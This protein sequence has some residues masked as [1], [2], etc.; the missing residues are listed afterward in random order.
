MLLNLVFLLNEISSEW[1]RSPILSVHFPWYDRSVCSWKSATTIRVHDCS[2]EQRAVCDQF[3]L[4]C[5]RESITTMSCRKLSHGGGEKGGHSSS[6]PLAAR[7][8]C[9]SS[10]SPYLST[11]LVLLSPNNRFT[12]INPKLCINRGGFR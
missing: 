8:H 4:L 2:R 11:A 1:A 10:A 3:S 7:P 5:A 6:R 9:R 12:N